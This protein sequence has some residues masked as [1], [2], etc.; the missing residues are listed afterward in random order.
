MNTEE[1]K[2]R[3]KQLLTQMNERVEEKK[4]QIQT[5]HPAQKLSATNLIQYLAVRSHDVR[6]LQDE[7]HI[8]GLSSLASC[9]SH[10]FR[11][12]QAILERL[13]ECYLESE[14]SSC[15]YY[16]GRNLIK[17]RSEQLF[18]SKRDHRIPYLM[19][20]F[21]LEFTDNY[22]LVK[23]LLE[24]GMNI[25]RI[26]CAHDDKFVW[27]NMISL[28]RSASEKTGIPCKIYMDIP[29]PKMRTSIFG[30]GRLLGKVKMIEGQNIFLAEK[31]SDYDP[32][33]IVIG[34]DEEGVIRQLKLGNR[35]LFDDGI[36]EGEVLSNEEG[37]A[38]IKIV[39]NIRKQIADKS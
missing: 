32:S 27:E 4:L 36:I 35:V 37:I 1:V 10:I 21:D 17:S 9:E 24:T 31:N 23:K 16:K 29:G 6:S 34:C 3:L 22:R 25:A 11:Q 18:G 7:L 30:K 14:I 15:T 5:L 33:D 13:G 8:L 38:V 28:I 2:L 26:N 39:R 12:V 20:T 19:V